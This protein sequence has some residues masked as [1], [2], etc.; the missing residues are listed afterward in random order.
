MRHPIDRSE[1]CPTCTSFLCTFGVSPQQGSRGDSRFP[2]DLASGPRPPPPR[3]T[4]VVAGVVA[5]G[6]AA[7]GGAV[8]IASCDATAEASSGFKLP[9]FFADLFGKSDK[10]SEK[11]E[12]PNPD[13]AFAE[14]VATLPLIA[15]DDVR[16][17]TSPDDIWVT[18]EGVVYDV[19]SFV[20][21]HPGGKEL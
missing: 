6:A 9:K 10:E 21:H 4:K 13:D 7:S 19:T 17:H 16:K 5:F 3:M 2:R 20:Q 12:E 18:Y 15:L 11:E 8:F 1:S 14:M